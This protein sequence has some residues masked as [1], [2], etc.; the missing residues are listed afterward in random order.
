MDCDGQ[1]HPADEY[2]AT[3]EGDPNASTASTPAPTAKK[4]GRKP[5]TSE[6]TSKRKAQNRAAQ[7]AFRERKEKH[8]KDLEEKVDS[9]TKA[10]EDANNENS[11]LRAQIDRLQTELR[12]YKRRLHHSEMTRTTTTSSTHR[13]N[14]LGFQ[15]TGGFQFDFPPFGP[16]PKA[17][18]NPV[19]QEIRTSPLM[20]SS[21]VASI[22]STPHPLPAPSSLT[23]IDYISPFSPATHSR[24][25]SL[26][27]SHT[28]SSPAA[29]SSSAHPNSTS[30]CDT[31][32]DPSTNSPPSKPSPLTQS[33]LAQSD[34]VCTSGLLSDGETESTFCQKLGMACGNPNNPIPKA[35][36][37]LGTAAA[38]LAEEQKAAAQS[39]L[40][41]GQSPAATTNEWA[42]PS[43]DPALNP[44]FMGYREGFAVND[45]GV[46]SFFDDALYTPPIPSFADLSTPSIETASKSGFLD[47]SPA[48]VNARTKGQGVVRGGME[49][50]NR[51]MEEL[52]TD[53]K[54]GG[55]VNPVEVCDKVAEDG[56]VEEEEVVP[57]E[58]QRMLSCNKI[59]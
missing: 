38:A 28:N 15:A 46:G 43:F 21:N 54:K 10:S 48:A 26:S 12:E 35:P 19:K 11:L 5:L 44:L 41:T 52:M 45:G 57:A 29:S 9:L 49:K 56:G 17:A 3:T 51:E 53:G 7:R 30:S 2:P 22:P 36:N 6:P 42:T 13:L 1:E 27:H 33:P 40:T 58:T 59:W 20:N 37:F 8:L 34:Y 14:P 39:P 4:P 32:P 23:C 31:S 47:D 50:G 24:T 55:L 16:S 25:P 18:A